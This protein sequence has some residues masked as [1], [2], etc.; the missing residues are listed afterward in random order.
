MKAWVAEGRR[1]GGQRGGGQGC[2]APCGSPG[3]SCLPHT[4]APCCVQEALECFS[5]VFLAAQAPQRSPCLQGLAEVNLLGRASS[6]KSS[7]FT[8]VWQCD[9]LV[10]G[11]PRALSGY[12]NITW[13][14]LPPPS[15]AEFCRKVITGGLRGPALPTARSL[16]GPGSTGLQGAPALPILLCPKPLG[17]EH[18]KSTAPGPSTRLLAYQSWK[19]SL[20]SLGEIW[21]LQRM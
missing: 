8:P 12:Q 18:L 2:T 15:T 1:Q 16:A 4:L 10:W 5:S 3:S 19:G 6:Q 21:T 7:T 13:Q 20:G 11:C 9:Q 14:L 17:S